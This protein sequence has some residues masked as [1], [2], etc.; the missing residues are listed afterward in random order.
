MNIIYI[1]LCVIGF[2]A[3]CL[4]FLGAHGNN[5]EAHDYDSKF[6]D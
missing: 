3:G 5:F 1:V 6:P 4:F 2:L